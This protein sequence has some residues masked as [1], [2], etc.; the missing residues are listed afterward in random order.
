MHL[1]EHPAHLIATF[2][3]FV[4]YPLS[5]LHLQLLPVRSVEQELTRLAK[6]FLFLK[7]LLMHTKGYRNS[8]WEP[9]PAQ[10]ARSPTCSSRALET[11]LLGE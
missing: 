9:L 11:M 1:S 2:C 4:F 7:C 6:E 3:M 8:M 10:V 5:F